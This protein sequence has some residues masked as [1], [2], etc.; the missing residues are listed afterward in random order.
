VSADAIT[1]PRVDRRDMP[2]TLDAGLGQLGRIGLILLATDQTLEHEFRQALHA[3]PGT[4]L[5]TTRL[6]NEVTI[7]PESLSAMETRLSAAAATLV[8]QLPLDVVAYACT[9]ATLMIGAHAV[10]ARI[11]EARPGVA[12]STPMEAA[13]TA[14]RALCLRRIAFLP[15]YT[16]VINQRMREAL[17]QQGFDVPVMGSWNI[18]DDDRVARLDAAT[19]RRDIVAL[20]TEEDVDGVFVACTNVRAMALIDELEQRLDK[21]VISSNSALIWDCLRRAGRQDP[22]P[23]FGQLLQTPAT[24]G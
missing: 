12:C 1:A 22:L 16:D 18:D 7:S 2:S 6:H 21:P 13:V 11:H 3:L 24:A 5:Y 15:P 8:P 23:G 19:L 14:L 10:H 17:L 4:E 9:S 20:G